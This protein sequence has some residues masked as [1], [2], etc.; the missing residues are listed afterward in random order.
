M[1]SE[2]FLVEGDRLRLLE[3]GIKNCFS[4]GTKLVVQSKIF[5]LHFY[6]RDIVQ[7]KFQNEEL[8]FVILAQ[9]SRPKYPFSLKLN[10][11]LYSRMF[12]SNA[13]STGQRQTCICSFRTKL[14]SN[15]IG[16]S[17]KIRTKVIKLRSMIRH[18]GQNVKH[19]YRNV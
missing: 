9:P 3:R 12:A 18:H 10:T 16:I 7:Y 1:S 15:K 4:F 19:K 17:E 2:L 11:P 14:V 5:F 6:P 13:N 8:P